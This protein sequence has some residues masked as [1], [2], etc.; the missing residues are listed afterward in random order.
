MVLQIPFF[1]TPVFSHPYKTGG[2]FRFVDGIHAPAFPN[3]ESSRRSSAFSA[4]ACRRQAC[5]PPGGAQRYLLFFAS[6][7]PFKPFNFQLS[8][9]NRPYFC[10]F[11][12]VQTFQLSTVDCQPPLFFRIFQAFQTFQL[13]TVDCQPPLFFR[14]FQAFQTF[15]LSTVDCQPSFPSARMLVTP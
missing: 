7:E 8:T 4:P 14:I 15:Q 12:A 11:Q 5:P 6:S 13:S 10:I 9:V 2:V 1:A 3:Q